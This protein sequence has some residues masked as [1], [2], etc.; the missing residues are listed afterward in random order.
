MHSCVS[1]IILSRWCLSEAT[2]FGFQISGDWDIRHCVSTHQ[3]VRITDLCESCF[4]IISVVNICCFDTHVDEHVVSYKT[5]FSK[6]ADMPF[7]QSLT[8]E[9]V[10]RMLSLLFIQSL[11]S[12][13]VISDNICRGNELCSITIEDYDSC[14]NR[15][16]NGSLA[17]FLEYTENKYCD[18]IL[19]Y[20]PAAG[21]NIH[22]RG[23]G[24]CWNARIIH[25]AEPSKDSFV[26]II[27]DGDASCNSLQ[28]HV[29]NTSFVKYI[30][31]TLW[32]YMDIFTQFRQCSNSVQAQFLPSVR[33]H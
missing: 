23:H 31:L 22:C 6:V 29:E 17:S 14:G 28:A 5:S 9:Q 16:I 30:N 12:I 11:F 32:Q 8:K 4:T 25:D 13:N 27:C 20:C 19:I 21:C 33:W 26:E 1:W 2:S 10:T 24:A 15:I 7:F 18:S 3:T